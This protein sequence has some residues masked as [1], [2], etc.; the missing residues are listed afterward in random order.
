MPSNPY[1]VGDANASIGIDCV[2]ATDDTLKQQ[3]SSRRITIVCPRQ[4]MCR[5]LLRKLLRKVITLNLLLL[6]LKT[7]H[8]CHHIEEVDGLP[9]DQQDN[10]ATD[11]GASAKP[12]RRTARRPPAWL[13]DYVT[14]L[15]DPEGGAPLEEGVV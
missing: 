1:G 15:P 12:N 6:S 14:D 5:R 4:Q 2:L 11:Q 9:R 10:Q 3:L 8:H 13:S 7:Q